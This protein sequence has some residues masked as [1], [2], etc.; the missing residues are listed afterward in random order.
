MRK[1]N[2]IPLVFV[3]LLSIFA[4]MPIATLAFESSIRETVIVIYAIPPTD[5]SMTN[6]YYELLGYKWY[7]TISYYINPSNKYGFSTTN[8]VNTITTSANTWDAQTSYAVFSY[9]GT[10]TRAAGKRDG[11]NVVA[12]GSYQ[13][14]AIA[15]TYIWTSGTQIIETDCRMNTRYKWS[16]TGESSKMDVQNIMTHEFGHW[17]GLKDLYQDKDYWLTMYGYANYG[18]TY[19]RTLGLGDINGLR[20]VYGS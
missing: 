7:A 20:S 14:G 2:A 16:L 12:W 18:E 8:V 5:D 1:T 15:V 6:S 19:K 4:T 11:Y 9:K 13:V 17:C 3:V 10:T